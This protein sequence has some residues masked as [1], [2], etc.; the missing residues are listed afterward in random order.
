[1]NVLSA[2]IKLQLKEL[3]VSLF[4]QFI[5]VLQVVL[6]VRIKDLIFNE[7]LHLEKAL[8]LMLAVVRVNLIANVIHQ[9][10]LSFH[11]LSEVSELRDVLCVLSVEWFPLGFLDH[12]SYQFVDCSER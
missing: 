8:R 3:I 4:K 2:I 10:M 5:M 9:L 1:L 7:S 11:Q 6:D 12:H